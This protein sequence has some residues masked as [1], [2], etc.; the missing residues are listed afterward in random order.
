MNKP[1]RLAAIVSFRS[2]AD[3]PDATGMPIVERVRRAIET[4]PTLSFTID[5]VEVI[6]AP[7]ERTFEEAWAEMVV[8]FGLQYGPDALENVRVGWDL[9]V[10]ETK[11]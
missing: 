7:P 8:K 4:H 10:R 11:R 3:E 1:K 2:Y 6:P 9:H 5:N